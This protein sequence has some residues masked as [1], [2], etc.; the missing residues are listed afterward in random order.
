MR[1]S[2]WSNIF[3]ER[4]ETTRTIIDRHKSVPIFKTLDRKE[5]TAVARIT[6]IRKYKE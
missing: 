4:D 5:L 1:D 2:F 3:K 6:H